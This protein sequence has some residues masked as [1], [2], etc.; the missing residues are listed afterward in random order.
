MRLAGRQLRLRVRLNGF[1]PIA[2]MVE[3][4]VGIAVL[5]ENYCA[6]MSA[7]HEH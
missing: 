3:G 5:P 6:A 7:I 2:R 4:G 1:A